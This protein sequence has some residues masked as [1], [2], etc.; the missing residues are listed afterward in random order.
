MK[1]QKVSQCNM[2]AK[3]TA[4]GRLSW[5][6]WRSNERFLWEAMSAG[7]WRWNMLAPSSSLPLPTCLLLPYLFLSLSLYLFLWAEK[8]AC[9]CFDSRSYKGLQRWSEACVYMWLRATNTHQSSYLYFK[10]LWV[11]IAEVT[12]VCA[13]TRNYFICEWRSSLT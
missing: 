12:Y 3:L 7:E 10:E 9:L 11:M 13:L 4:L 6:F 2:T 1:E 8:K 5:L